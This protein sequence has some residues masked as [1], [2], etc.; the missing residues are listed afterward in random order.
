M[1]RTK[2]RK[3]YESAHVTPPT[4]GLEASP[5]PMHWGA[6]QSLFESGQL[7]T[8]SQQL[9][10][11]PMLAQ[12]PVAFYAKHPVA[13][14]LAARSAHA[15]ETKGCFP[16]SML[17]SCHLL[18]ARCHQP[19]SEVAALHQPQSLLLVALVVEI[20][21][22]AVPPLFRFPWFL[23]HLR[24]LQEGVHDLVVDKVYR[25]L[26]FL[27]DCHRLHKYREE[28]PQQEPQLT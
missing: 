16:D 15:T 11:L 14:C 19:R 9:K 3:E 10:C 26:V 13:L 20:V 18:S 8:G 25:C 17:P 28:E 23:H 12:P 2:A 21:L 5:R 22:Q 6:S 24:E 27:Q 7:W 1:L 4:S